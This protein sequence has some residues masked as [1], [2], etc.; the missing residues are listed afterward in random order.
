MVYHVRQKDGSES[1]FD[2][3]SLQD[4]LSRGI[5]SLDTPVRRDTDTRW[6]TAGAV[7]NV[8]VGE[9]PE[10]N[11]T[12]RIGSARQNESPP[13]RPDETQKSTRER[14]QLV[15][16]GAWKVCF[17]CVVGGFFTSVATLLVAAI[18]ET[19]NELQGG[20]RNPYLARPDWAMRFALGGLLAAAGATFYCLHS[21]RRIAI[22]FP[23]SVPPLPRNMD[24]PTGAGSPEVKKA[25]IYS[26]AALTGVIL[27]LAVREVSPRA[28]R[29]ELVS[30]TGALGLT[31]LMDKRTGAVWRYY[32][33]YD[34]NNVSKGEG[35]ILIHSS[36]QR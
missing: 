13:S 11:Q 17:A 6:I 34:S 32:R 21:P 26:S 19:A 23:P 27:Y 20:S 24:Q 35:F 3:D 14:L 8:R 30:G 25:L 10:S 7:L 9:N 28:Q 12:R 18:W 16:D 36:D 31:F 33:N 2:L 29:F 1:V 5:I 22:P 15:I 4:Q